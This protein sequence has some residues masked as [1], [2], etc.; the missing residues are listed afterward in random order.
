MDPIAP[1]SGKEKGEGEQTVPSL[2]TS[3]PPLERGENAR[4]AAPM[5]DLTRARICHRDF[6]KPE[7]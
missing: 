7:I 5:Q 6:R 2:R 4:D 1:S 3:I